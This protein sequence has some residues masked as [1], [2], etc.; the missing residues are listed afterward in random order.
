MEAGA[1]VDIAR[2]A[3]FAMTEEKV[4]RNTLEKARVTANNAKSTVSVF[5]VVE[6]MVSDVE[7]RGS[8]CVVLSVITKRDFG[9]WDVSGSLY[10]R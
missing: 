6:Y 3:G 10:I 4:L 7:E 1:E 9:S 8:L 2:A 5:V